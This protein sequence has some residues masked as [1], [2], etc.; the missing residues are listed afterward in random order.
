MESE[1]DKLSDKASWSMV[2]KVIKVQ[3]QNYLG[4]GKLTCSQPH[5]RPNQSTI[6]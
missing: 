3:G 6:Q 5:K 1:I 4:S 2:Y